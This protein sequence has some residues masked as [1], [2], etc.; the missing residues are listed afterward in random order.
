MKKAYLVVG[1]R[2]GSAVAHISSELV[3]WGTK[4]NIINAGTRFVKPPQGATHGGTLYQA[5]NDNA[6]LHAI[7]ELGE[8]LRGLHCVNNVGISYNDFAEVDNHV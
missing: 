8:K 4:G 2:D 1:L 5:I 6:S 3:A 7:N